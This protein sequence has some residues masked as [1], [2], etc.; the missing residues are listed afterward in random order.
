MA[1]KEGVLAKLSEREKMQLGGL[2]LFLMCMAAIGA[3][4]FFQR[5]MEKIEA[6]TGAYQDALDYLAMAGP[7]Y[8]EQVAALNAQSTHKNIDDETL[9]NN[10]LKLTS[11]VA[12]QAQAAKI[13]VSSYDEDEMPFG[14]KKNAGPIVIE[15][16]L[17]FEIRRAQMEQLMDL[18]DRIHQSPEPVFVKRLDIRA[19]RNV[20]GEVRAIVTVSTYVKRE[21]QS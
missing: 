19:Q 17:R 9:N 13:E 11:F 12:E 20:P 10:A 2:G 16:Q 7:E 5:A 14:G 15:K 6:S 8:V 18:L 1:K 21:E 3:V 4:I